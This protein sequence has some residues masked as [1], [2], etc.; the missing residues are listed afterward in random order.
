M[1]KIITKLVVNSTQLFLPGQPDPVRNCVLTN[2]SQT[3]LMV[4]CEAGYNGGLPQRFHLDVYN[5]AVDHLQLNMTSNDAPVFSVGNLPPGTPFVLVI[6]A[7]NEK[8][9]S[10]SVAL[11]GNTLSIRDQENGKIQ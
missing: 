1:R 3:W 5:S 2:R 11:L 8:G 6:Y 4:D 9:K 10:N 7:S